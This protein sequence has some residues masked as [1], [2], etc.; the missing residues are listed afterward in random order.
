MAIKHGIWRIE[1]ASNEIYSQRLPENQL[2]KE[3]LLEKI[4]LKD[5]SILNENWFLI[6]NQVQTEFNKFIDLLAIDGDG[7]LIIIELKKDKTPRD[8]IAQVLDYASWIETLSISKISDIYL[9]FT[10][11]KE[12]LEEG[13]YKKFGVEISSQDIQINSAHQMVVVATE[14]DESTERIVNYLN[15]NLIDNS[16]INVMFF[17]VFNDNNTQYL[18][19]S[20]L[21]EPEQLQEPSNKGEYFWNNE[22]Y[23][24]FGVSEGGRSWQDAI[25]Y[26]FIASGGGLWYSRTL[27]GL[28]QGE[29]IWVNVPKYGYVGVGIV[30][31]EP[32]TIEQFLENNNIKRE[33]LNGNYCFGEKENPDGDDYAVKIRWLH[34]VPLNKAVSG[35]LFGNQNSV[36]RPVTKKWDDTVNRL[37][38]EWKIK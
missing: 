21:I 8:V 1:N 25:K 16:I 34:T 7:K 19:R 31:S 18:S 2:D 5:I 11:E 38:R 20:W 6:G 10:N 12:T 14:L 4:I 28:K 13:F 27:K 26:N 3:K 24:N 32:M 29:R 37:K 23:C 33:E 30:E 36:A 35:S 9:Q 15:K 17:S 22:V